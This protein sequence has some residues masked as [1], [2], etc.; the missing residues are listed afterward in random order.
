MGAG[1]S[2]R[3]TAQSVVILH[4]HTVLA[5]AVGLVGLVAGGCVCVCVE[6]PHQKK[7]GLLS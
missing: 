4:F 1:G 2:G 7:S 5:R 6:A 3:S